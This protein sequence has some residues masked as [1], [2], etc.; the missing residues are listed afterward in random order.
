M[1]C[2]I[3]GVILSMLRHPLQAWAASFGCKLLL[4][5]FPK[6]RWPSRLPI[7]PDSWYP[8]GCMAQ[9]NVFFGLDDFENMSSFFITSERRHLSGRSAKVGDYTVLASAAAGR[10]PMLSIRALLPSTR[11]TPMLGSIASPT[12]V[13]IE[14]YA[15][16]RA[17]DRVSITTSGPSAMHHIGTEGS[18][19][20]LKCAPSTPT[21]CIRRS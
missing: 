18:S 15:I 17:L 12:G 19:S 4:D 2:G 16:G 21:I 10:R 8:L 7:P 1:R 5:C 20:R 14:P 6:P 11:C 9:R 13:S 3:S